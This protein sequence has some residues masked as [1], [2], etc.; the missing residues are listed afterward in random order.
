MNVTV[1]LYAAM[2][3]GGVI[4]IFLA[5]SQ[6]LKAR[7][8]EENWL[9]APGEVLTSELE[10]HRS[11]TRSGTSTTYLPKVTYRYHIMGQTYTGNAIGFGK[12]TYGRGKA[13]AILARYPLGGQLS[14]RY[15]PAD[16]TKA[17]L[18]TKAAGFTN[19][20]IVGIALLVMGIVTA[21]VM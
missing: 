8:A 17:V 6:A 19:Y 18:E 13:E 2:I 21:W 11:H 10:T 15:D 14:V 3:V 7:K 12:S 1:I 20:L 9:T 4:F 16:P 5:V